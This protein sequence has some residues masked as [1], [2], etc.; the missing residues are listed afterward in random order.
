MLKF[1]KELKAKKNTFKKTETAHT[2]THKKNNNTIS[3]F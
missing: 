3:L 2:D 1:Y